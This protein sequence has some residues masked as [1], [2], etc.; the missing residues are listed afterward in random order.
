MTT[1]DGIRIWQA[2][3]VLT[4]LAACFPSAPVPASPKTEAT[5]VVKEEDATAVYAKG[6]EQYS[7]SCATC[8]LAGEGSET[9]PSLK[10]SAIL[11]GEPEHLIQIILKGQQN[12][13][14]INGKK[15]NGVMPPQD[16]MSDEDLAAIASYVRK[17]FAN[18]P[19]VIAPA[20]VAEGRK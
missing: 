10:T 4:L 2:A 3:L 9:V 17:E 19:G 12:V 20:L 18:Q 8:H 16:Y 1:K 13:S 5:P 15:V 6:A 11:A 7:Q 14:R